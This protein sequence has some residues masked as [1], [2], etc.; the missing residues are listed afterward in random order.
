MTHNFE[1]AILLEVIVLRRYTILASGT[2]VARRD[3][4]PVSGKPY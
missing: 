2:Q 1:L 4:A 3:H